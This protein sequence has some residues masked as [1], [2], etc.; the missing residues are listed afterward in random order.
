MASTLIQNI[1]TL[2]QTDNGT[3]KL[4][5]GKD[6]SEIPHIN[7]AWLLMENDKITGFGEMNNAPQNANTIFDATDKMVLP[8]FCDSHT[9]L[10]FAANRE[11]EFAMRIQGKSYEEI[12]AA[13]GGILNS[14]KKLMLMEES[15]LFDKAW[16]RLEELKQLGTGAIEIK[17]GYGLTLEA[18]LKM[19]R[20]IRTLREKSKVLIRSTFLG[21]HAIPAEY[22]ND[23]SGYIKLIIEEMLPKIAGEGLADYCDV[24]CEKGYFTNEETDEI[25]QAAS[26]YNLK[27]KIH[28]NQFTNSGGIDIAIKNNALSVDH[29]EYLNETEIDALKNSKTLPVALPGCSFFINIPYTPG[30]QIIDAGLPLI[31]ASDFNPGTAP[32][33]NMAF[34]I[35]LACT[36]M[37]LTPE[38]AINAATI[39]G[40]AAMELE[41]EVGTIAVGKKANLILT[42]K[43]NSLAEIPYSFASNLIEKVII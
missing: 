20:V 21:A 22:K 14:V 9:H 35:A 2:W 6:M 5:S 11:D 13:G 12:A 23:R 4:V 39:N 43:I 1:K 36:Q 29:L 32:S 16:V 18:E 26:K 37:K 42:K 10:V 19:L 41:N 28:V 3:R 25:L 38:E 31:L 40:A 15:E 30:R 8:A 33:G 7:N 27:G 34:V 24:F 17:S